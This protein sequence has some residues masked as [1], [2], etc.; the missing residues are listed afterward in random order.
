MTCASFIEKH[1]HTYPHKDVSF[2]IKLHKLV[3]P[4]AAHNKKKKKREREKKKRLKRKKEE[5]NKTVNVNFFFFWFLM[6]C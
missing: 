5:D 6:L 1:T 3:R 2:C 4:N